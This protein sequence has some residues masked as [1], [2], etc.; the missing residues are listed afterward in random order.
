MISL[1]HRDVL[2]VLGIGEAIVMHCAMVSPGE[3][4]DN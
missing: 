1:I 3:G 4:G 2:R